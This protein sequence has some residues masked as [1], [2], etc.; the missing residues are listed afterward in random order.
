MS[1]PRLTPT[2]WVIR[3][4]NTTR[5]RPDDPRVWSVYSAIGDEHATKAD[6]QQYAQ[7]W[8]EHGTP[9]EVVRAVYVHIEGQSC[10]WLL[11]AM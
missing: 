10:G 3:A 8:N 11:E 6:A 7:H 2:W 4:G 9:V 1:A 5:R